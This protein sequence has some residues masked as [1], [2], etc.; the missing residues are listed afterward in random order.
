MTPTEL[1]ALPAGT[2]VRFLEDENVIQDEVIQTF[3]YGVIEQAGAMP[4]IAWDDTDGPSAT[5]VD[6]KS[7]FWYNFIECL[8]LEEAQ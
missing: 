7:S 3:S 5:I 1:A 2:R 6:T 8:S 4:Q